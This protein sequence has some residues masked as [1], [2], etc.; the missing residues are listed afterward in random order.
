MITR[1]L[2]IY[3]TGITEKER[4]SSRTCG[5]TKT[6]IKAGDILNIST[7]DGFFWIE[8]KLLPIGKQIGLVEKDGD[9][10]NFNLRIPFKASQDPDEI[11]WLVQVMVALSGLWAK[12]KDSDKKIEQ[13]GFVLIEITKP[14]EKEVKK[15]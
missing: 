3:R 12:F 1:E 11:L 8:R 5:S 10:V 14:E 15:S 9:S 6:K 13:H 7:K 2:H 4:G